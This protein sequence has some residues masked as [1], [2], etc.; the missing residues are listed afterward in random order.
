MSKK[1]KISGE[2]KFEAFYSS[3]YNDRWQSLKESLLE[4]K[5]SSI[6]IP[7]LKSP[8]YIDIASYETAKIL[9]VKQGMNV[10]DMCAAPGG[11]TLVIASALNGNGQLVSNDRSPDRRER[12]K[13]AVNDCLDEHLSSIIKVTG[14]DASKWGVYEKEV[15]DA[16]LLDA[17]CSS[18]RHVMQSKNHLSIWSESRPKRLAIE[19]YAMLSSALLALKKGG[20]ILY[21]T[22]SINPGENEEVI[23]KLQK[24][25]SDEFIE[26]DFDLNNSEKKEFGRLILPDRA[27]GKGP[28]YACLLRKRDE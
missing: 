12:L 2:E 14:Y 3:I 13:K 22:C 24:K 5:E 16:I 19:Q 1:E 18:E 8:Y 4:K 11:K 26:V 28:M 17:P 7:N 15:Y 9:P 27:N 6:A 21:S 23:K 25:H 10:L 20:F